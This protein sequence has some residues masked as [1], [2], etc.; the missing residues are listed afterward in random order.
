MRAYRETIY[1]YKTVE[2]KFRLRMLYDE[3]SATV[4]VRVVVMQT[5]EEQIENEII[6]YYW[7]L[8]VLLTFSHFVR[9]Y[10]LTLPI[11]RLDSQCL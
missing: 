2:K 5:R 9:V 4:I 6:F 1:I 11:L 7:I 3:Q 10:F 8:P